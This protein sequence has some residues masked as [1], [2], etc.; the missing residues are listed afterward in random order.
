MKNLEFELKKL[1]LF[2]GVE[3]GKLICELYQDFP[4]DE[5]QIDKY[6]ENRAYFK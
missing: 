3:Y 1:D 5:K 4:N 2:S 6:I